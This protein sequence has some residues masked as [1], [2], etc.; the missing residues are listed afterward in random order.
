MFYFKRDK[1][2]RKFKTGSD[3]ARWNMQSSSKLKEYSC[4][5]K[6]KKIIHVQE[7]MGNDGRRERRHIPDYNF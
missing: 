7:K 4:S 5:F 3:V 2:P 1:C 6:F